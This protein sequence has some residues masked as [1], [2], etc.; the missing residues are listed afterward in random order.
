MTG[1]QTCALPISEYSLLEGAVRINKLADLCK[2]HNMPAVAVTDTNNMFCALEFSVAVS[3]HG[4]Q[5][6][7]GCQMDLLYE[8]AAR[9]EKPL[10]PAAVVL[11]A[12]NEVGY[13]NLLKL[14]TCLYVD[15]GG[16]A[17]PVSP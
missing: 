4:V 11:L 6:I 8:A 13:R 5:T 7:L 3:L 9:G 12:Q 2:K 10:P 17:P 16:Q 1:V 15:A 14:N